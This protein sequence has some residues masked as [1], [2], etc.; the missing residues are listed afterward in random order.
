MF[1]EID[2][3][4]DQSETEQTGESD[5]D[6]GAHIDPVDGRV[7]RRCIEKCAVR[8]QK[9][10]RV[11][12]EGEIALGSVRYGAIRVERVVPEGEGRE[13]KVHAADDGVGG[14]VTSREGEHVANLVH[15]FGAM[16]MLK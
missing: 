13:V 10:R 5:A 3:R 11:R 6:T 14:I 1:R 8:E 2:Q 4:Q 15:H 12:F 7:T 9:Y 16:M